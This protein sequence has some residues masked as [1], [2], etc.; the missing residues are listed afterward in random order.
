MPTDVEWYDVKYPDS[1]EMATEVEALA[2]AHQA[3]TTDPTPVVLLITNTRREGIPRIG[4]TLK[5]L[6]FTILW[7]E[8]F[9]DRYHYLSRA[10]EDETGVIVFSSAAGSIAKGPS[11]GLT[12]LWHKIKANHQSHFVRQPY[13]VD[14]QLSRDGYPSPHRPMWY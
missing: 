12:D 1:Q 14:R 8:P 6:G 5:Q 4:E 3:I 10:M 7:E 2:R 13:W 9:N 11:Q